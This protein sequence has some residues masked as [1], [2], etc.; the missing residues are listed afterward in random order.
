MLTFFPYLVQ[1]KLGTAL[2]DTWESNNDIKPLFQVFFRVL[3]SLF[4]GLL[5]NSVSNRV[6][7][8]DAAEQKFSPHMQIWNDWKTEEGWC[9]LDFL[10]QTYDTYYQYFP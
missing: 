2:S 1:H 7:C 6:S 9:R 3:G 5:C 10:I 4:L 8:S